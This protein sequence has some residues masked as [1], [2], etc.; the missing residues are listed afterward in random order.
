[1]RILLACLS[2]FQIRQIFVLPACVKNKTNISDKQQME[3]QQMQ[4][5]EGAGNQIIEDTDTDRSI[6]TFDMIYSFVNRNKFYMFCNL[7]ATA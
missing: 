5:Y 6:W 7:K 4:R 3:Q 1:M 2:V